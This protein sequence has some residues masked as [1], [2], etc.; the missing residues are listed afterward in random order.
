MNELPPGYRYHHWTPEEVSRFWDFVSKVQPDS[1]FAKQVGPQL[2]HHFAHLI[3]G[4][5]RIVDF[6]CGAGFFLEALAAAGATGREI[7][8]F[9]VSEAS[10]EATRTRM[11]G[12]TGF[13]GAFGIA[14]APAHARS[15]DLGFCLEVVEHLQDA[16]LDA[17][18]ASMHAM[19][20]PGGRLVV[21][22]P[23]EEDL[24]KSWIL[25]PQTGEVI[26][27]WQHVRTWSQAT[28]ATKL[29]SSGFTPEHVYAC[30][31]L[32]FGLKP[33]AIARRI[34]YALLRRKPANLI[35]VAVRV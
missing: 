8:G 28:L 15:F 26:H 1:Y 17:A 35:A 22:T 23:N 2:V 24:S 7:H 5:S 19:L 14:K 3:Q 20:K 21:T 29:R 6:G 11:A 27:R 25:L 9:D 4:A 33:E 34:G 32:S 31:V 16:E 30:N 13:A 10:L 12:V 18:L